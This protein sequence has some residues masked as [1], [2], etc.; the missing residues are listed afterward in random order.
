MS[1]SFAP[2]KLNCFLYASLAAFCYAIAYFKL[3]L[4]FSAVILADVTYVPDNFVNPLRNA[5]Q[6]FKTDIPL[7]AVNYKIFIGRKFSKRTCVL[8]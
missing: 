2:S 1:A 8:N 6:L 7:K 5:L 3:A 4:V